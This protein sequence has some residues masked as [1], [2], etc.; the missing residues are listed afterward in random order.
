MT[1]VI[2]L[3]CSCPQ[4]SVIFFQWFN[5]SAVRCLFWKVWEKRDDKYFPPVNEVRCVKH[6]DTLKS[7]LKTSG[8]PPAAG[9]GREVP[10]SLCASCSR[11]QPQPGPSPPRTCPAAAPEPRGAWGKEQS[12]SRQ[13]GPASG[14]GLSPHTSALRGS[15]APPGNARNGRPVLQLLVGKNRPSYFL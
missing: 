10:L 9:G 11:C 7:W 6:R 5:S 15:P 13:R 1:V 2:H 14:L 3:V 4:L 8:A 12:G